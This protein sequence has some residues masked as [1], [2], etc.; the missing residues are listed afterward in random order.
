MADKIVSKGGIASIGDFSVTGS[1]T[2]SGSSTSIVEVGGKQFQFKDGGGLDAILSTN[3]NN[4]RIRGNNN[5]GLYINLSGHVSATANMAVG[6]TYINASAPPARLTVKGSGTTSAT[7]AFRVENAN[8]SG[9]MVVRD[10]GFV[11]IGTTS[12]TYKLELSGSTAAERTI[13]VDGDPVVYYPDQASSAYD[14]S[15]AL[16]NGLRNATNTGGNAGT[17]NTA[18][19]ISNQTNVT[20]GNGNVSVGSSTLE[21]NTTG[22][23]NITMGHLAGQYI[24][25]SGNNALGF[26]AMRFVATGSNNVAL[27]YYA[28]YEDGSSST[29]TETNNSLYLGSLSKASS[30]TGNTNE[31]VIGY[32]AQGL[33]S[34]TVVLGNDSITTTALKGNV[35]IGTT[36]PTYALEVS[37]SGGTQGVIRSRR[38]IAY[39]GTAGDPPITTASTIAGLFEVGYAQL[40]FSSY[41]GEA[42]RIETNSRLWNI[43]M[44][45]G[46]AK[47]NIRGTGATSATTAFRVENANTSGSMVI[48]DDGNVGIGTTLPS[49]KLDVNGNIKASK[50]LL[51]TTNDGYTLYSD[52]ESRINGVIF[53]QVSS[54]DY[55]QKA[56]GTGAFYVR[57]AVNGQ[58]LYV[59]ANNSSGLF[60]NYLGVDGANNAVAI[61]TNDVTRLYISSSGNVGI[62]TTSPSS[63]L[64]VSGSTTIDNVLTLT[65]QD[66]L[67]TSPATGSFAVSA[68]VPPKPYFYDGTSWNALY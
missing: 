12:P 42:G 29:I 17:R 32:Q 57:N 59:G 60:T 6:D 58:N 19:G 28:G 47:M 44:T 26:G 14:Y 50:L 67:P 2:V 43:G 64:H 7:T 10:N 56:S 68:S 40:G 46:T 37:G 25:Q 49:Q 3:Y 54:T 8:A 33:G 53:Q 51:N 15:V 22:V 13:G 31:I 52:G 5:A 21:Y 66:P 11:G 41:G 4:F 38:L 36:S 24:R 48:L 55:L 61:R 63:S 16:G 9:S 20:T 62:G 39:G 65:P 27:G 18:I 45:G 35:G 1:L 30:T 34:N 23:N